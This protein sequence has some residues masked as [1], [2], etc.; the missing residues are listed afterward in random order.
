[1]CNGN[2]VSND[3]KCLYFDTNPVI[4]DN[5]SGDKAVR[6]PENAPNMPHS[7]IFLSVAGSYHNPYYTPRGTLMIRWQSVNSA[8]THASKKLRNQCGTK[9]VFSDKRCLF[10]KIT[11]FFVNIHTLTRHFLFMFMNI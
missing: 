1:M 3:I 9:G 5:D 2:I 4:D 6:M 10:V 8:V 7:N 11:I